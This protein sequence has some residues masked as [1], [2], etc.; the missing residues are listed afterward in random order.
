MTEKKKTG[1]LK[2]VRSELKKVIWPNRKDTLN[3][4]LIVLAISGSVALFCWI[5]DFIYGNLI[6]LL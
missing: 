4:T 2:G 5:L 6:G 3:Y 1:Y